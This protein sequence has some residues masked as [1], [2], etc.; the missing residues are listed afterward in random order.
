MATMKKEQCAGYILWIAALLCS[1]TDDKDPALEPGGSS[2]ENEWIDVTMRRYYLWDEEIPQ[3]EELDYSLD[4]KAFFFSL[5]TEKDG[6]TRDNSHYY[7][8]SINKKSQSDTKAFQGEGY[9]FGFEFQYYYITGLKKYALLVLYV[10]PGSPAAD[11]GMRRGDWIMEIGGEPVPGDSERLLEALDTASP[12]TVAFGITR[13]LGQA[14]SSRISVTAGVV[15]DN[16]VFLHKIIRQGGRRIAYMVYNHFT[17]DPAEDKS[18][19][20]FNDAMREA[21]SR[22]KAENPDEFILDLRYNGGGLVTCARL[23]STMLAPASALGDVFC[24]LEYNGHLTG[25]RNE[26][27][28]LE[29]AYMKG[30]E[31][32]DLKRLY[33]ITSERTAS[34]SEA[35]INCL[36]SYMDVIL[37]G[38]QTEGKNVGS[39]TFKDDSYEWELHPIVSRLSNKDNFSDYENGFAPDI[40][41]DES[42]AIRDGE[43]REL[44]DEKELMLETAL[45]RI[46][47]N[48]AV[49]TVRSAGTPFVPLYSSLDRK[50]TNGVEL[51]RE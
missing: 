15:E 33:V 24:H 50:K 4:A 48:T 30:G 5:L 45:N 39:V 9:S 41:C 19:G 49:S 16:P 7:Y 20:L 43:M 23:L 37:V 1:C 17:A 10:L 32:L 22:L 21:F 51:R 28:T 18:D 46:A 27:M 31:N 6:K 3:K 13:Q 29:S 34:A 47:G 44:G 26:T 12:V 42:D 36:R 14:V 2:P 11:K 25:Y 40:S 38:M 35:V 8:S